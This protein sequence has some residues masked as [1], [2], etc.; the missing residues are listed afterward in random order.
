MACDWCK[1]SDII[2]DWC[3]AVDDQ[4]EAIHLHNADETWRRLESDPV[5]FVRFHSQSI[6][7]QLH[8]NS[9]RADPCKLQNSSYLLFWSSV[10]R[11]RAAPGVQA[12]PPY[13]TTATE[14]WNCWD[15]TGLI[16]LSCSLTKFVCFVQL[17]ISRS[18]PFLSR[19][20]YW[21]IVFHACGSAIGDV[22]FG[23][24]GGLVHM[25]V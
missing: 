5:Q 12:F 24:C 15:R 23:F 19:C 21:M 11:G 22:S 13:H 10:F 7:N 14:R 8:R 20:V 6:R 17:F 25:F 1:L 9:S 3:T 18:V 2:T 16:T 4:S